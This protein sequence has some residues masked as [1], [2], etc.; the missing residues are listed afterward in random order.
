M[1]VTVERGDIR[2]T[3]R[4]RARGKA[5]NSSSGGRTWRAHFEFTRLFGAARRAARGGGFVYVP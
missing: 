1:G 5:K 2:R 3:G 4:R